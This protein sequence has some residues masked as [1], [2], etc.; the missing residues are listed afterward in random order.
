M[1]AAMLNVR[2]D[3]PVFVLANREEF[4]DRPS[5]PPHV[6]FSRPTELGAQRAWLGG[7]DLVAGGTWLGLNDCGLIVALTNRPRPGKYS[8]ARSR[9][10]L[11]RDLLACRTPSEAAE[12]TI[13]QLGA[14]QFNGFS[15]MLLSRDDAYIV[16]AS[17]NVM[18]RR[19]GDGVYVMTN[20]PIDDPTDQRIARVRIELDG[21]ASPEAPLSH[22]IAE[23]MRTCAL[24]PGD[25]K[26]AVCLEGSDRGTVSSTVI[27]LAGKLDQVA[28]HFAPG[29]PSSTEYGDYS[30]LARRLL[31][32]TERSP[33]TAAEG[34]SRNGGT[35]DAV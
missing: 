16:E 30:H 12:E 24:G 27:A 15:V 7:T 33:T 5:A 1:L 3:C 6:H 11:C 32:G 20:G 17:D 18:H 22:W 2:T 4:R 28:Y 10:L 34:N 35:N 26:P 14:C 25:G 29:P 8:E 13:C 31:A 9:G 21:W 23:A 19:L